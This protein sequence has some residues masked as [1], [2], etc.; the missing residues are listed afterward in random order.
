MLGDVAVAV[1]P[2]D[3]RYPHLHGK[4]LTLPLT[5]REIPVIVDEWVKSDFGTGAVKV[6]PAHDPNDFAIGQRHN[7]PS[8]S[9][10]GRDRAHERRS[11][12]AYAG[13]DRYDARKK[14]LDDL[15]AQGLLGAGPRSR[16]R[17][18]QVRPL[19][20]PSS[21][22]AFPPSGSSPSTRR[23]TRAAIRWRKWP[24]KPSR[25][26]TPATRRA[27]PSAS[28]RRITRRSTSSG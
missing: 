5:D 7:L 20:R 19:S 13:L 10:D 23:R 8:I 16:E 25:R 21:S 1:N 11:R 22:R 26:L 15:E 2:L 27:S 3:E 18:R 4:T 24:G 9:V 12:R 28:R 6:T 14:V 17:Y